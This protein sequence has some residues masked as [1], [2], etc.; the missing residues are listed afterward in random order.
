[1]TR[2]YQLTAKKLG[3]L[4][5][6]HSLSTRL[7]ISIYNVGYTSLL[8][9]SDCDNIEHWAVGAEEAVERA[10]EVILGD[11]AGRKITAVESLIG[12][13]GWCVGAVGLGLKGACLWCGRG[14]R[15]CRGFGVRMYAFD[16]E[17][18]I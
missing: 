1:M 11:L 9:R 14:C 2:T 12:R 16:T 17:E 5:R 6:S 18:A 13:V 3:T 15:H 7:C 4:Q 10:L 8:F